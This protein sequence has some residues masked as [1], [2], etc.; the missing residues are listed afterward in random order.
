MAITERRRLHLAKVADINRNRPKKGLKEFVGTKVNM[1]TATRYVGMGGT[2]QL[3][4]TICDCG[5]T[6]VIRKQ[7]F[8]S[9]RT[10]SCGCTPKARKHG[11][12]Y[13]EWKSPN[14]VRRHPIYMAWVNLRQRCQNKSGSDYQYYGG[15]GI[16]VC[17]RWCT[18]A[19][20]YEDMASTWKEGLT[21]DRINNNGD[22][23][24]DNCRWATR[25]E[26]TRNRRPIAEWRQGRN[27]TK[28]AP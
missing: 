25:K 10:N 27:H 22:Y 17:E 4:E 5:N 9:G 26:Q 23:S 2:D 7:N 12:A 14:K 13:I 21:I 24:P 3:W 16:K 11:M 18:F 8:L 15:R 1:L 28:I 19:N 20:F 6:H